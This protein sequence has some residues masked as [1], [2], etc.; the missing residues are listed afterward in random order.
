MRATHWMAAFPVVLALALACGSS[1]SSPAPSD[2]VVTLS[3]AANHEKGVN[4]AGG[5]Y[6]ISISG[7]PA[8]IDVPWVSGPSAP[9]TKDVTLRTGTY[10]VSVSAY[11]A[12]DAQGGTSGSQSAPASITVNVP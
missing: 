6:R 5:G 8:P 9:T 7:Q 12:L 10:T 2:H 11:A 3:W 1:S 4:Q